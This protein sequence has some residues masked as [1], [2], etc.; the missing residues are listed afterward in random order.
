MPKKTEQKHI[1]G[2][3]GTDYN[4]EKEYCNHICSA[5]GFKPNTVEHLDAT[6][7]G[8][9]SIQSAEALKR[10]KAKKEE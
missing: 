1:C 3:C 7:G 8:K 10:G 9:F 2:A 5:T 6:S 4:T